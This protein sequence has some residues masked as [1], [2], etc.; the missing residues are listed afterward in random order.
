MGNWASLLD[1]S[2]VSRDDHRL[3]WLVIAA[4][5]MFDWLIL[6]AFPLLWFQYLHKFYPFCRHYFIS[7]HCTNWTLKVA[8]FNLNFKCLSHSHRREADIRALDGLILYN[9]DV[10]LRKLNSRLREVTQEINLIILHWKEGLSLTLQLKSP[11]NLAPGLLLLLLKIFNIDLLHVLRKPVLVAVLVVDV[12]RHK[13]IGSVPGRLLQL[14]P[15]IEM[16]V[17]SIIFL[18][19]LH[20]IW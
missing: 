16:Y 15:L 13:L 11:H 7:S 14:A 2:K 17:L 19:L 6:S 5:L 4:V 9:V 20:P 1:K 8:V 18:A 10:Q 3:P 12:L